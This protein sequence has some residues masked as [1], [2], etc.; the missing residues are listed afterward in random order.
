MAIKAFFSSA[1]LERHCVGCGVNIVKT[2]LQANIKN[3]NNGSKCYVRSLVSL[4]KSKE[5]LCV[6]QISLQIRIRLTEDFQH[7]CCGLRVCNLGFVWTTKILLIN[8]LI[9][10]LRIPLALSTIATIATIATCAQEPITAVS[11]PTPHLLSWW[12]H[13]CVQI[14]WQITDDVAAKHLRESRLRSMCWCGLQTI[15]LYI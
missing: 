12:M 14:T 8:Y 11:T 9:H 10:A 7:G 3:T 2:G 1:F 15:Y 4:Y 6:P 5:S 13:Q